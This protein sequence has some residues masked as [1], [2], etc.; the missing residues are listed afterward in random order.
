[1]TLHFAHCDRLTG[2]R[3]PNIHCPGLLF[4]STD[5]ATTV[6]G[7]TGCYSRVQTAFAGAIS[8]ATCLSHQTSGGEAIKRTLSIQP[9]EASKRP[10]TMMVP[11]KCIHRA[12]FTLQGQ[13]HDYSGN[14]RRDRSAV[15]WSNARS[16][17][18]GPIIPSP[19]GKPFTWAHGMETCGKPHKPAM[20][21]R[22]SAFVRNSSIL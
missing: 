15:I 22:A 9:H 16:L 8:I 1:V 12:R 11:S 13:V 19:T 18:R 17:P 5:T 6:P 20:E 7:T 14:R 2:S 10:I 21:E 3:S 4:T